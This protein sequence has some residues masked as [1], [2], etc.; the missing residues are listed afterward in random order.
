MS[1]NEIRVLTA[2][3]IGS[4]LDCQEASVV[5]AVANAYA[6]YSAGHCVLPHS[7]FI[8]LDGN[9]TNRVIALPGYLGGAF[10]VAGVKWIASVPD[11]RE[12][13][14]ERASGVIALNDPVTGRVTSIL[15]ASAIN[16]SRTAAFATFAAQHLVVDSQVRKIG[17]IG[18]G[19]INLEVFRFLQFAFPNIEHVTIYDTDARAIE[20]FNKWLSKHGFGG[21]V[22]RLRC[23][24]DVLSSATLVSIAT[25]ATVPYLPTLAQ[26]QRDAVILHLSLRDLGMEA[27][28]EARNVVD[29]ANHVCRAKTSVHLVAERV[30]HRDFLVSLADVIA[31]R[32]RDLW[33]AGPI[34]FSP[35]GLGVLDLA[36]ASWV[37][38]RAGERGVGRVLHGFYP[39]H[40]STHP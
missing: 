31:G 39:P 34:V 17:M 30:G 22:E 21:R 27:I 35:F 15:E 36:V 25:T 28:L 20:S 1:H 3:E 8:F 33:D 16:A 37:V 5:G 23:A 4:L 10:D 40:W 11:N 14:L 6:E 12:K 38:L 2:Q 24:C 19:R 26:A 32:A 9:E 13:G 29:D 18:L 7:T